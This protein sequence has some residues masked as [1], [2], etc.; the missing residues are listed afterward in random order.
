MKKIAVIV[1]VWL[2]ASCSTDNVLSNED[3][4]AKDLRVID[5]YLDDNNIVATK[6]PTGLRL[7]IENAGTGLLPTS[8]S[9][10][11][12]K[13]VGKFMNGSIFDQSKLNAN[14][15][16][17]PFSYPL[18]DQIVGWQIAF[19]KYLAKGGK[20]TLYIPSVLAYGHAGSGPIPANANLIFEVEFIG[21]VN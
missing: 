10:L 17:N 20:A 6:D 19:G 8:D 18:S 3:Q 5:K 15:I 1:M 4:L 2:T 11:T 21:F 12:V 7:V 13:Y 9:K 14:G 16:P